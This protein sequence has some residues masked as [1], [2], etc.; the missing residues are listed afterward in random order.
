M[1]NFKPIGDKV[2]I[3]VTKTESITESG[4]HIPDA[5]LDGKTHT[6]GIVISVGTGSIL[7]DG[8]RKPIDVS[9]GDIVFF[10]QY[11]GVELEQTS[12]EA[13][14]NENLAFYIVN[15]EDV[16]GKY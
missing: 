4:L 1:N 13:K 9:E 2:L 16:H 3:K 10:A 11:A 7:L 6:K 12:E 8:S 5:T 14:E 15:L